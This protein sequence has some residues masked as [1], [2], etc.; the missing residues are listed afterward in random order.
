MSQSF[1]W[2]CR[3]ALRR[4]RTAPRLDVAARPLDRAR[5][6]R[7]RRERIHSPLD[8][9]S[10][11]P[12][13]WFYFKV[14]PSR[15]CQCTPLKVVSMLVLSADSSAADVVASYRGIYPQVHCQKSMSL[16]YL[17]MLRVRV[18]LQDTSPIAPYLRLLEL[19][20]TRM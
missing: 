15:S 19:V 4:S 9:F 12:C 18:C 13:R 7:S 5:V 20:S 2:V 14:V 1:L 17:D 10:T 8:S 16:H 6:M 11:L 3:G